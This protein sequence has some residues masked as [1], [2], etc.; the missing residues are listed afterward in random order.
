[1]KNGQQYLSPTGDTNNSDEHIETQFH[2]INVEQIGSKEDRVTAVKVRL[3]G[4]NIKS[5]SSEMGSE[6]KSFECENCGMKFSQT[7]NCG[8]I[9]R[10]IKNETM[11]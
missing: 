5:R 11:E 7:K 2:S 1:V 9:S 10:H 3:V 4:G 8:N 6:E